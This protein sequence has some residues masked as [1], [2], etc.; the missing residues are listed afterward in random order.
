M[1]LLCI[2]R[3]SVQAF[4]CFNCLL[5]GQDLY[6]I[7]IPSEILILVRLPTLFIRWKKPVNW[8]V[9]GSACHRK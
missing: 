5:V 3:D 8:Q 6:G 4:L 1:K 2:Y 7:A 9:F